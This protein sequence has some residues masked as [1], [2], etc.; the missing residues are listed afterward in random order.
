MEAQECVGAPYKENV[1]LIS[2]KAWNKAL[3]YFMQ[4]HGHSREQA[5]ESLF[6]N[7]HSAVIR[8]VCMFAGS[9]DKIGTQYCE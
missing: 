6:T 8:Q 3:E 5:E 2:E 4:A 9:G 1:F 7:C